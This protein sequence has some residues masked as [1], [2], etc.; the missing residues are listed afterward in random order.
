VKKQAFCGNPSRIACQFAPPRFVGIYLEA[1]SS[2]RD[3][4]E[5][6]AG[7]VASRRILEFASRF[8]RLIADF[9]ENERARPI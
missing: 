4:H 5:A 9:A 2:K 7:N 3:G 1:D 6:S 8:S